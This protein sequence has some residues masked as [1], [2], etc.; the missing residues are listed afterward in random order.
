M[1]NK[2]NYSV[3]LTFLGDRKN[4]SKLLKAIPIAHRSNG[5]L[6][7]MKGSHPWLD[8]SNV[9]IN[10]LMET[11]YYISSENILMRYRDSETSLKK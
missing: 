3:V 4:I 2:I 1:D 10:E 8:Y 6:V 9:S 5:I 7:D 11:F